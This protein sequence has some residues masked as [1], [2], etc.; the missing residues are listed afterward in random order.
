MIALVDSTAMLGKVGLFSD[1]TWSYWLKL[2]GGVICFLVM[3]I[4][5]GFKKSI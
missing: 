3:A 1:P 2:Q 4:F 5:F